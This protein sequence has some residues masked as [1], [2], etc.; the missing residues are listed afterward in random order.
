MKRLV[1]ILSLAAPAAFAQ[2]TLSPALKTFVHYQAPV[3]A[4]EHVRVIDGTGA[5][6]REDQTLVIRG[7][8]ILALGPSGTTQVPAGA[9]RLDLTGRSV[10]PGLVDMHDHLFYTAAP[11]E[12]MESAEDLSLFSEAAGSYPALFLAAGVT[13]VRTAGAVEPFTDLELRRAIEA[14]EVPGP[15]LDVTGPFLE[16]PGGYSLQMHALKDTNDARAMVNYWADQGV[17]SVK[18]Y[19]D[20]DRAEL[21]ASAEAAHQRKLKLAAHVCAVTFREATDAGVDSI[22]HGI[23]WSSDFVPDKKPDLCPGIMAINSSLSQLTIQSEPVQALIRYMVDHKVALTSTLPVVEAYTPGRPGPSRLV[24][25]ALAPQAQMACFSA[26]ER[27][28]RTGQG[29]ATPHILRLEMDFDYAFAKAGGL[30]LAGADSV[31][32]GL[33]A[34]FGM[35]R[36]VELLVEAGFTP[37]EAIKTATYNG[38]LFLGEQD[39]IGTIAPGKSADVVVVKGDPARNISDIEKVEI[40]FKDGIGY[41]PAKL[42]DSVQGMVGIQ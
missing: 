8:K 22:E 27:M 2:T 37:L 24:L 20:I 13:R 17:T 36:E 32:P 39:S 5:A 16:G 31:G 28:N 34:G 3:I 9:R 26:R 30:L 33:I 12:G 25:E 11:A 15:K 35:Q 10:F 6:A 4:L 18:A 38:A 41:D 19:M 7:K 21:K 14:G 23:S 42:R 1:L 40:V 29:M